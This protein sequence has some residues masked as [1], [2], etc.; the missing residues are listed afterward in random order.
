MSEALKLKYYKEDRYYAIIADSAADCGGLD[1][2]VI[3]LRVT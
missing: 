3:L 1:G 2:I